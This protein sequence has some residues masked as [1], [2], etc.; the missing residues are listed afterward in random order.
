VYKSPYDSVHDSLGNRIGIQLFFCHPLQY[1]V[2]TFWQNKIKKLIFWTPLA[3]N[4][5]P[6]RMGIRMGN[7]TCRQPLTADSQNRTV[8]SNYFLKTAKCL[9]FL[10]SYVHSDAE[11]III[12]QFIIQN[13]CLSTSKKLKVSK[14][15]KKKRKK[16]FQ[17]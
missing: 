10:S 14:T 15:K 17:I 2:Y 3:A 12:T 16:H 8:L 6:N 5:T 13:L 1:S 9:L 4:L 7:H 11:F